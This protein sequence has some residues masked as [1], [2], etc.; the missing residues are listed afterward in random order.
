MQSVG[1][2]KGFS[3]LSIESFTVI[4]YITNN[5][6]CL[7]QEPHWRSCRACVVF[8]QLVVIQRTKIT[9][10]TSLRKNTTSDL[11]IFEV[12]HGFLTYLRQGTSDLG[13]LT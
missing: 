5:F 7:R 12:Y 1:I 8:Q 9:F 13:E 3:L 10:D 11:I 2:P 4:T 6:G